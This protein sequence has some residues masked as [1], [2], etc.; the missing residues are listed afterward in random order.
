MTIKV[1]GKNVD[2]SDAYTGFAA[3]RIKDALDKYVG[4]DISGHVRLEKER[5]RFRTSCSIRLSSGLMLEAQGGGADAYASVDSA[6]E[7][8]E[9]RVRRHK[10]RLKSHHHGGKLRQVVFESTGRDYTVELG[11]DADEASH[12]SNPVVVA[13]TE[14]R[15]P[16]L[17]VSEAVM[18]LD[19]TDGKFLLFRNAGNGATNVIYRREDGNIGWIDPGTGKSKADGAG[20]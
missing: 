13:E 20:S 19:L 14:F 6:V 1:T 10:R 5:G 17:S 18:Q 11:D 7:K 12:H 16:E 2:V 15:L 3:E 4:S 8:L 9:K